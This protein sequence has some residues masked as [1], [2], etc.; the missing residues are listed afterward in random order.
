[1]IE[2]LA[3]VCEVVVFPNDYEKYSSDLAEDNKIFVEGRVSLEEDKDGKLICERITSFTDVPKKLYIKFP[4][5]EAYERQ[6]DE[7]YAL[8]APSDGNDSVNIYIEN[9]KQ[10]KQ[11][12][13]GKNVCC[14]HYLLDSLVA[15]FGAD[16]IGVKWDFKRMPAKSSYKYKG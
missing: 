16:N 10:I 9:P 2:D 11:L 1:M 13:P 7:M 6:C 4:D 8:L 15:R 3:G 14:D 5:K 12:P